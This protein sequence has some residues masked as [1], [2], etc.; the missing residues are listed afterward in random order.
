MKKIL[1][2]SFL[3][4]GTLLGYSYNNVVI[5]AQSSIFPKILLLDK[6]LKDKLVDGKIVYT[7]ICEPNDYHA[8]EILRD[9]MNAQYQ[10]RLNGYVFEVN[11]LLFSQF[12]KAT[13][14]TAIYLLNSDTGVDK[15]TELAKASDC[16]TF[17]YDTVNLQ[18][19]VLLS[20][21]VEKSTVLYLSKKSLHT[22][23]V[24]FTESLYQI[25]R[26]FND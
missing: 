12:N 14:A 8:A 16:I 20:L 18:H 3:V 25:V 6:K 19:G 13:R 15:V 9:A 7:I 4:A 26:I 24:E 10:N 22:H 5:K 2:L 11:I 1:L 21:M 17:A 23:N